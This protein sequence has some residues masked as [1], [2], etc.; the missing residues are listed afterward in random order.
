[1]EESQFVAQGAVP[2]P[3][4]SSSASD[5]ST[6]PFALTKAG[7]EVPLQRTLTPP[8]VPAPPPAASLV[9]LNPGWPGT[10]SAPESGRDHP[11]VA[12]KNPIERPLEKMLTAQRA[13]AAPPAADS[14]Q[15][16]AG[17]NPTVVDVSGL[18]RD[19]SFMREQ[20]HGLA[21][22]FLATRVLLSPGELTR[23]V[24]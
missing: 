10:A 4:G 6:H 1:N 8:G 21:H 14:A 18:E 9:L 17:A 7:V 16:S 13:S 20:G 2:S 23:P 15:T 19:T 5:A 11:F 24:Y 3:S 22:A 12:A